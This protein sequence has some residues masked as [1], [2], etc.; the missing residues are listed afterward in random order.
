MTRLF[1]VAESF[2][3]ERGKLSEARCHDR[4]K[5][6]PIRE[7]FAPKFVTNHAE[8]SENASQPAFPVSDDKFHEI[9]AIK[10]WREFYAWNRIAR[11]K[12]GEGE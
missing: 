6:S 4:D 2:P 7:I 1:F 3:D 8:N 9:E 11:E 5:R 12:A 10:K